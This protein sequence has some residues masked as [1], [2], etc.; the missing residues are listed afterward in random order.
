M[1]DRGQ[2]IG[3]EVFHP[4]YPMVKNLWICNLRIGTPK[5]F[6]DLGFAD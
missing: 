3:K 2:K 1:A 6:A 4:R 5:K